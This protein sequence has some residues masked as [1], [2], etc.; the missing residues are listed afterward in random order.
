MAFVVDDLGLSAESMHQVKRQLRKFVTEQL[1]PND[2]V[3]IIRTSGQMGALQQF[4][5]D[6]RILTRAV[7]QLRWNYCS[8][9]GIN[10]LRPTGNSLDSGT[11]ICG[12]RSYS[13]TLKSLRFVVDSMGYLPGRKSL[14]LLSDDQPRESQD[15]FLMPQGASREMVGGNDDLSL[16]G[17]DTIN[18]TGSLQK[19]AEK[20][21]RSSVV[22]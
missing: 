20:A 14:V 11:P 19:I 16:P 13:V 15:E 18:Y 1:Q 9:V 12:W 7:D 21:I 17:G 8:R 10:V 2:L 6:K 4:T 3:A 22:I 5:N